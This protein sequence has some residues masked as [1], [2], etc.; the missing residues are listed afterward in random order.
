[1]SN[2]AENRKAIQKMQKKDTKSV[3]KDR[4]HVKNIEQGPSQPN[5]TF[6]TSATSFNWLFG[7]ARYIA[8]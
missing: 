8:F 1:M 6:S 4:S 3:G 5:T 7:V 2:R